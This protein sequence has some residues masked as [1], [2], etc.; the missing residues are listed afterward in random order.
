MRCDYYVYVLFRENGVPFYVGKGKGPRW[1]AH[2][3]AARSGVWGHKAA[4]IRDMQARAIEVIKIKLHESLSE[5]VAYEYEIAL[6][7]A[8][9]R[10]PIG[11]LVNLSDG[12][13]DPPSMRGRKHSPETRAKM[14]AKATGRK[15]SPESIAK[16][17]AAN[18]GRKLSFEHRAK[19]AAPLIGKKK[20][21]EAIEKSVAKRRGRKR[22]AESRAKMALAKLG[23]K[24][25]PEHIEKR[26]ATK[27]ANK[28]AR[29]FTPAHRPF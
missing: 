26:E 15:M 4:I 24:Q 5:G 2:E 1:G 28:I 10:L 11:P 20:S 23:K 3:R 9:G 17:V 14:A 19:I 27:R 8:I 6:I 25:S 7:K 13:E 21:P 22:T 18:R 16:S 29:A 12:G